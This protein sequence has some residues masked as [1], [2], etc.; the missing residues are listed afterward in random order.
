MQIVAIMKE[1]ELDLSFCYKKL[2]TCNT[3]MCVCAQTIGSNYSKAMDNRHHKAREKR[4][5]WW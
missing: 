5:T 1:Q 2:H 3:N 4:N